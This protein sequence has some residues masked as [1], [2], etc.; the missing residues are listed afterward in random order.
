MKYFLQC[1]VCRIFFI[2]KNF[3]VL[4]FRRVMAEIVF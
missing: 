1:A 4:K 2:G 3:V